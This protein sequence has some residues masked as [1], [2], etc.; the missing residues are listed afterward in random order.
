[1]TSTYALLPTDAT[2]EELSA[3]G[4][5][6]EARR[7]VPGIGI[8]HSDDVAIW[9]GVEPVVG[10]I[11]LNGATQSD[12]RGWSRRGSDGASEW[13]NNTRLVVVRLT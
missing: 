2:P 1:M 6:S 4:I 9:V 8:I 11:D 10:T 5:G 3:A 12:G 13:V 7:E